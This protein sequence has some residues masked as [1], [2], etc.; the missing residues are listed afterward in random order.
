MHGRV[1]FTVMVASPA[2]MTVP[3][4]SNA[5]SSAVVG[6]GKLHGYEHA[7]WIGWIGCI[8]A[9]P[10]IETKVGDAVPLLSI[11]IAGSIALIFAV[12]WKRRI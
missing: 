1:G 7:H 6:T 12:A 4:V 11:L 10:T 8:H 2:N 5:T 9:Y 3:V